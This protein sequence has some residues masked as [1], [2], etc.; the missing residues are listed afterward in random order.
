MICERQVKLYTLWQSTREYGEGI[1][2]MG[3]A[4]FAPINR[5]EEQMTS[6]EDHL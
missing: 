1:K 6:R 5:A 3:K 2:L 4:V